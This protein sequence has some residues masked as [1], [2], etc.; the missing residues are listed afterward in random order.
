MSAFFY[1]PYDEVSLHESVD[2]SQITV[3][4]PWMEAT[5][6][7]NEDQRGQW[8]PLLQKFRDQ[9][10][11]G[12]DL[13]LVNS[14]FAKFQQYPLCYIL[15]M[16]KPSTPQDQHHIHDTDFLQSSLTEALGKILAT[17]P[18]SDATTLLP[19][20]SRQNWDW[21]AETA[22][23]FSRIGDKVHPES[24][25]SVIRRYHL[26]DVL[27]SNRGQKNFSFIEELTD[28][29]FSLAAS[30]M[31]RQ[32]HYVTQKCNSSLLPA[33]ET[34][35][36]AK[37]MVARFIKEE[38]GHDQ[39]LNVAMKSFATDPEA[40]PVSVE[41][42]ALMHILQYTA[43]RNFL[44]FAMT[45][46]FFE[47][48]SYDKIDP[49]ARLLMKGGFDKAARQI[50]RHME[51]N[52]AGTHENVALGFLQFMSPCD[53]DYAFE[54]MRLAEVATLAINSIS[55]SAVDLYHTAKA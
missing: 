52:D 14:F 53:A 36:H 20:L 16:A 49:L 34:A 19:K 44:A 40:V 35:G 8:Q 10:L 26:L 55:Q 41:T 17:C 45:V 5:A 15:P 25:F 33:L 9:S 38:L 46:N 47:R 32:N 2:G 50:N 12:E 30:L 7:L 3:K 11:A 27:D 54:A 24:L 1:W 37:E 29:D 18:H 21:D 51:I 23:S 48:S 22:L 43:E 31:V 39:I 4:T 13:V 6:S 42:K 28:A